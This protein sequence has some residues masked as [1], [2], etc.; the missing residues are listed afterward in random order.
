MLDAVGYKGEVERA[1]PEPREREERWLAVVE[2]LNF[3]RNYVDRAKKPDLAG[4]LSELTLSANDEKKDDGEDTREQVTL[5]TLHAAKG[6]EFPRVFLVGVEEGLLPHARA[7]LEGTIEEERRLMYV[8]ITRA[9][10]RLTITY[11]AQ[12]AKYGRPSPCH[13][14]RFLFEMQGKEPPE[15]WRATGEASPPEPKKGKKKVGKRRA[16]ARRGR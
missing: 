6:L 5:M 11:C 2:V 14:S 3:A 13:P 12:R 4:F 15:S 8:G 10:R 1:Y 9:K 7:A 16:G